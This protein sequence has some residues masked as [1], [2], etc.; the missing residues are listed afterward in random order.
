[1]FLKSNV[2]FFLLFLRTKKVGKI[3]KKSQKNKKKTRDFGENFVLISS[4]TW[5]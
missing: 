2:S 3:T 5:S 4:A 1:M